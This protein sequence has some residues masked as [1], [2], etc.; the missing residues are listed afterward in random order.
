[1]IDISGVS[2][3]KGYS[4]DQ[5]LIVGAITTLTEVLDIFEKVSTEKEDEFGYLKKLHDHI[6]LV[7][8]IPVRNVRDNLIIG[9][10]NSK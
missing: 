3:L 8:H 7:A 4:F 10:S 1:M 9:L 2:E 6:E 5:N